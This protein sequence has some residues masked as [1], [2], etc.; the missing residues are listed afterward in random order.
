MARRRTR[1]GLGGAVA[2]AFLFAC[3]PTPAPTTPGPKP[4][5]GSKPSP[6]GSGAPGTPAPTTPDGVA[7][8]AGPTIP[9]VVAT[10]APASPGAPA[11]TAVLAGVVSAPK[12]LVLA[13]GGLISDRGSG[14]IANNGGGIVSNNGGSIIAN[15]GGGLIANNGGGYRL[16]QAAD[17][18]EV[19][20]EGTPVT[21]VDGNGAAVVGPDGKPV[22]AMTDAAG[23]YAFSGVRP[24]NH[25]VVRAELPK[26]GALARIVAPSVA[27]AP[28]DVA[29]TLSTT[30]I[31]DKYVASQADKQATLN[32]LP[33]DVEAETVSIAKAA[34]AGDAPTTSL[35]RTELVA[36]LD[37]LRATNTG[38]DAQLEKVKKLLIV[39]GGSNLGAGELATEVALKRFQTIWPNADGSVY[40]QIADDGM[41]WRLDPDGRLRAVAGRAATGPGAAVSVGEAPLVVD[42]KGRLL[43]G[44]KA[45]GVWRL[46]PGATP[47]DLKVEALGP[48]LVDVIAVCPLEGDA[49]LAFTWTPQGPA[50]AWRLE[51]GVAPKTIVSQPGSPPELAGVERAAR[52]PDGTIRLQVAPFLVPYIARFDPATGQLTKLKGWASGLLDL[53]MGIDGAIYYTKPDDPKVYAFDAG[54]AVVPDMA[55]TDVSLSNTFARKPGGGAYFQ[56]GGFALSTKNATLNLRKDGVATHLA[57]LTAEASAGGPGVVSLTAP[58]AFAVEADGDLLVVDNGV[59]VR[60]APG[61]TPTPVVP[62]GFAAEGATFK[63]R[64]PFVAPDGASFL[65]AQQNEGS[66]LEQRDAVFRISAAGEAS[67]VFR[68]LGGIG[69]A[70]QG[71]AGGVLFTA[72][73]FDGFATVEGQLVHVAPDGTASELVPRSAEVASTRVWYDG[74]RPVYAKPRYEGNKTFH[75]PKRLEPDGSVT[76]LP[77]IEGTPPFIDALGRTYALGATITRRYPATGLAGVLAGPNGRTFAGG[78]VDDGVGEA[79]APVFGPNGDLYF[80]DATN[81]QIKRIPADQ[82]D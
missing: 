39:A 54:D 75:L 22:V 21:L 29:S 56:G 66:F 77:E 18:A 52:M 78:G 72:T 55:R 49:V 43:G 7:G 57:G 65:V 63:A 74:V 62:A 68:G 6:G 42:A 28:L 80:L 40:L 81:R 47:A 53:A 70:V 32:R 41:L 14:I 20:L 5:P 8:S 26:V 4:G 46:T 38:L 24:G 11:A 2:L 3:G 44:G 73:K 48:G 58:T 33:A 27:D 34:T 17:G 60:V 82:L 61:G 69:W 12:A 64:Y 37:A 67:L 10:L 51:A 45:E 71:P 1:T 9:P 16:A 13:A 19:P 79:K 30:Y 76:T 50:K 15:N 23:R 31:L 35:G 36:R 59:L 25:L